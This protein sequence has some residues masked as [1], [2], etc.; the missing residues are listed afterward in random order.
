MITARLPLADLIRDLDDKLKSV[1]GGFASLSYEITNYEKADVGRLEILVAGQLVPGLTRV[2][3]KRDIE[4]EARF[5]VEKLKDLLPK[6]QFTQ[7]IQAMVGGKIIA[8]ENIPALKKDV[9][10][11]LYGGDR[12][13]KMKL[14]KKQ[15]KGKIS[16]NPRFALRFRQKREYT[17]RSCGRETSSLNVCVPALATAVSCLRSWKL[18]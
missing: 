4:R 9:T 13:R 18:S 1:S 2:V 16:G 8:R 12:T 11:Y 17:L 15:Q 6:Q 10:G 3:P 14:W 7:A 5:T